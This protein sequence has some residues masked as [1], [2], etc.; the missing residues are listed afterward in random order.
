MKQKVY[1]TIKVRSLIKATVVVYTTIA[2]IDTVV[3]IATTCLRRFD[4]EFH[5]KL[6]DDKQEES[7]AN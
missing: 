7:E 2:A 6:E 4:D 3:G 1:F 5:A